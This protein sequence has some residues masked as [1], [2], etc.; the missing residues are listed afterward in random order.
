MV[1][2]WKF[3]PFFLIVFPIL[4]SGKSSIPRKN[5]KTP[6]HLRNGVSISFPGPSLSPAATNGSSWRPDYQKPIEYFTLAINHISN[7]FVNEEIGEKKMERTERLDNWN[8]DFSR[9]DQGFRRRQ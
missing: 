6:F 4:I 9:L 1:Q 3:F 7:G 2:K 5:R 8:M